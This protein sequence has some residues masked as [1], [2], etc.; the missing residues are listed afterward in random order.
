MRLG[1]VAITT[2]QTAEHSY[3]KLLRQIRLATLLSYL[4]FIDAP[5]LGLR[6]AG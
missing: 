4:P 6:L 3:S 1:W 2:N 5:Y